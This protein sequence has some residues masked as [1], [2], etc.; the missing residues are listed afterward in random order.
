MPK[1]RWLVAWGLGSVSVGAASLLVPLYVVRLGGDPFE[2]GLLGAVAAFVGAPGALVWGRLADRTSNPRGIVLFSL[3]GVA[4]LLGA[5]PLFSSIPVVVLGNALLW[6]AFAAA[7]PVLTLLVVADVPEREW[8]HEIALLNKYQ[9]YGWAAGLLLGIAWSAT[10]GRVL[11]PTATQ[12]SLFVA[13]AATA[14]AAAALLAR[15]MP[16]PSRHRIARVDPERV[17]RLLSVGR[18][19]V[20]GATVVFTPNRLYWST[21]QFDP[22]RVADRFTPTL[23]AYFL[24]VVLFFTGFSAFFAPLP[25]YLTD[26]GFSSDLV[27]GLYLVSSLG[28]AAFYTAA[29]RLS[30]RF[31]LRLLQTGALGVRAVAMPLVAVVGAVLAA[32]LA[33]TL[34]AVVLFALIGVT[35]SVVAVT[36]GTIV[37]RVAPADVRGEALGVYAALSVLAGGIGSVGGGALAAEFGFVVAFGVAGVVILLGAGVVAA[38]REISARTA[39]QPA[40]PSQDPTTDSGSEL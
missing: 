4:V 9:G 37:A 21:R 3:A 14:I 33:G 27:Y 6:L 11:S 19:G 15:W 39:T 31:D 17:G 8:T 18:R 28:S 23:A 5:I 32:G 13:C 35:W 24:G 25:L 7:G 12:Q 36:A 10:A 40:T 30:S 2:L 26:V 38:L 34:A 29:G 22:A 1:H 16:T 20:R